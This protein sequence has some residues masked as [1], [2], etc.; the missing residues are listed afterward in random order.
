MGI[1][2][3]IGGIGGGAL[4]FFAGG[5][6]GAVAGASIGYGLGGSIDANNATAD[7]I[8]GG[9][10]FR[11]NAPQIDPNTGI[12]QGS[13]GLTPQEQEMLRQEQARRQA[14]HG[15]SMRQ[16]EEQQ[17]LR[18]AADA[19]LGAYMQ[20]WKPTAPAR[21]RAAAGGGQN[22]TEVDD[23][24]DRVTAAREIENDPEY[25]RLRQKLVGLTSDAPVFRDVDPGDI[26]IDMTDPG[27]FA[28]MSSG[29]QGRQGVT[30]ARYGVDKTAAPEF[31]GLGPAREAE[32]YQM[33]RQNAPTLQ[34][35]QRFEAQQFGL[36]PNAGDEQLRQAGE[37]RAKNLEVMGAVGDRAMGRGGPSVAELQL[38]QGQDR[39][40][41]QQAAL[42]ASGGQ[43]DYAQARRQAMLGAADI[44][45]KTAADAG[46]LRANEQIAAQNT[47]GGMASSQQGADLNARGQTMNQALAR[48]QFL[49]GQ[50][51]SNAQFQAQQE[52]DAVSSRVG[53]MQF[54]AQFGLSQEQAMAQSMA[55]QRQFN[56]QMGSNYDMERARQAIQQGQFGAQFGSQQDQWA[57]QFQA[58]Q[59]LNQG[60]MTMQQRQMNDQYQQMLLNQ[61]MA[62]RGMQ[63]QNAFQNQ[64]AQLQTNA[65]NAGVGMNTM[66]AQMQ[67]ANAQR[68]Q[69]TAMLGMG[70]TMIGAG[71]SSGY[72]GGGQNPGTP[73]PAVSNSGFNQSDP[74]KIDW[75]Y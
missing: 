2:S 23:Y 70:A 28:A 38:K 41:S 7:A 18:A 27:R 1:W 52:R 40:I 56:T 29:A 33:Q 17:K 62:S 8:S 55:Q 50:S 21:V 26:G 15:D 6:A 44:S 69:S 5:P 59:E 20:N 16:W 48:S 60:T 13:F 68:Q 51:L 45:Q 73:A 46:I 61:Y 30:M 36:D 25:Q 9:N 72:F 35:M 11:A 63:Q 67:N 14:S 3:V 10:Q 49:S 66:N 74:N 53:Q 39:A 24:N 75:G 47:F 42:A 64:N 19:E 43:M 32:I 4:G 71:M 31:V 57:A 12:G 37:V 34:D 22:R 54:G 58:Q 65:T